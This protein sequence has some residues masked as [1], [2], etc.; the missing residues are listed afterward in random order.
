MQVI[1]E[2]IKA[3]LP[4]V[5]YGTPDK[6]ANENDRMPITDIDGMGYIGIL[7]I[8]SVNLC[9]PVAD[10]STKHMKY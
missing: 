3:S 4:E 1:I 5:T 9:I 10:N 6:N 8:E 2:Q 7:H